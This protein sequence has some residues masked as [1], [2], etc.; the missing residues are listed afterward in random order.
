M[1]IRNSIVRENLTASNG[2][3]NLLYLSDRTAGH[4][5]HGDI[6]NT[7]FHNNTSEV[8]YSCIHNQINNG[9][10]AA[11]ALRVIGCTFTQNT[12]PNGYVFYIRNQ[13]PTGGL[14]IRVANSIFYGNGSTTPILFTGTSLIG[15]IMLNDI[16]EGPLYGLD[17]DP[18]FN[19]PANEDFTLKPGSPAINYGGNSWI[20][21]GITTDLAGNNRIV[22]GTVDAG[23]YEV[24]VICLNPANAQL[25]NINSTSIDVS[26]DLNAMADSY[27]VAYVP[28]GQ[29]IANGTTISNI[30]TSPYTITGLTSNETY[31]V[32]VSSI[33]TGIGNA[34]F[35]F[36]GTFTA[37]NSTLYVDASATGTNDGT[38]WANAFT[39]LQ[40]ALPLV[41]GSNEIWVAAGTYTP[42][43]SDRKG[44]FTLLADTKLYGGFNGTETLL[45]E[46]DPKL[47]TTRLS[48]DLLGDD[49]NTLLHTEATRQDNAYHVVSIRGNVQNILV[50]GVTISGGNANGGTDASCATQVMSQYY[51]I[52]GAAIY[53]NP[54]TGTQTVTATFKNCILEKTLF[55]I[56]NLIFL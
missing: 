10:G 14:G 37:V 28:T 11:S 26:W 50:D 1:H 34:S 2:Y 15:N 42:H 7:V 55:S 16:V 46:R 21:A 49:N 25:S 18:L 36:V 17:A 54:H 32:Y 27:E 19:D 12:A 38:S 22:D 30:S 52:R 47:Y 51:D 13:S 6:I 43:A 44:T 35:S 56:K 3:A 41:N 45:S 53:T 24:T 48:G 39:D 5:C 9:T 31:D 4:N 20:P 29:P 8:G 40:S 23:A 33:C